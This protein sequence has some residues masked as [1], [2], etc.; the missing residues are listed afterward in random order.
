MTLLT[1]LFIAGCCAL[2]AAAWYGGE[3]PAD[4]LE[5]DEV[6]KMWID[7]LADQSRRARKP[8]RCRRYARSGIITR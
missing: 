4:A 8:K 2:I 3:D 6:E 7:H 5:D 1:C